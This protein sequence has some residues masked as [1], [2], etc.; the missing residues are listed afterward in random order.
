VTA[1]TG[2]S[3]RLRTAAAAI[4]ATC[5]AGLL[6]AAVQELASARDRRRFPPPGRMVDLGGRRMHLLEAGTG[7]P[8]LVVVPA[9]GENLLGWV[10]IQLEL[11]AEMRVVLYDRGGTGWSDPPPRG[12]STAADIAD[13]LHGLLS[14]AGIAPPYVL[15]AHSIGGVIARA[16]AARYGAEVTGLVLVD[17]SHEDQATRR[18]ELF[19]WAG[20]RLYYQRMALRRRVSI[21]GLR[22]LAAAA[23]RL[24][25]LDGD[26]ARA[27]LPEHAA[28]ARAIALSTRQRRVS[29]RET[30]MMSRLS[31]RPPDLGSTPL[32]VVTAGEPPYRGWVAMQ[33]EIAGL[34]TSSTRITAEG[35]GHDVQ[36]DD[37]ELVLRVIRDMARTSVPHPADARDLQSRHDASQ[38]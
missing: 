5:A 20:G 15:A 26:I 18:H 24:A 12:R 9:L 19:G 27:V 23:G 38:V 10:R 32:T 16:F 22:R 29:V 8:T 31:G 21:L 35:S 3:R 17:S 30:L 28:A 34:S 2:A 37:P 33:E 7:P 36:L 4:T 6:S 11:A 13:E 1:D 14:A 25:D